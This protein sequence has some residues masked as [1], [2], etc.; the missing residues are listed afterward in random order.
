VGF[1]GET[2]AL[3]EESYRFIAAQPL[4]YLHLFP[5]S[6]R[7]GTPAWTLAQQQPVAGPAVKQRMA[8]LRALMEGKQVAYQASIWGLRIPVVT[9]QPS[10]EQRMR[11]ITPALSDTFLPVELSGTIPANQM[12]WVCVQNEQ[13]DGIGLAAR[14]IST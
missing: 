9:L 11:G 2:D 13:A 1:P 7:P 10:P 8:R 12:L 4:T 14:V 3:F 6:A 5:F